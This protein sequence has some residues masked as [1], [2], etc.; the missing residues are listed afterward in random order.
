MHW[1]RSVAT[2]ADVARKAGVS[3]STTWHVLN[4]TRRGASGPAPPVEAAIEWFGDLLNIIARRV[5]AASARSI[6]AV[7]RKRGLRMP[8][9]LSVV[10]FDAFGLANFFEPR[11]TLV[12]QPS[13]EIG[14]RAAFQLRE[15]IAV[16]SSSR[17]TISLEAAIVERESCCRPK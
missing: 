13:P 16:P 1:E 4:G 3:V 7:I 14:R 5:K 10:D 6:M 15:R 12:A 2:I 8:K 17:R 9:D 11:L